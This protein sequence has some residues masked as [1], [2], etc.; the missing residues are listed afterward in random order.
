MHEREVSMLAH[1]SSPVL[2][3]LQTSA[4]AGGRGPTWR[5]GCVLLPTTAGVQQHAF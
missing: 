1:P 4:S 2:E 5:V 3:N